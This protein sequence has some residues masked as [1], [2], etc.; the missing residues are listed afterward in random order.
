MSLI[1][2]L[3]LIAIVLQLVFLRTIQSTDSESNMVELIR[4]IA[5]IGNDTDIV[6]DRGILPGLPDWVTWNAY[7]IW[8]EPAKNGCV[9]TGEA[10][11][12]TKFGTSDSAMCSDRHLLK[13]R[14]TCKTLI[15]GNAEPNLGDLLAQTKEINGL[16]KKFDRAHDCVMPVLTD[17]CNHVMH[18]ETY[19]SSKSWA[20][21]NFYYGVF[22]NPGDIGAGKLQNC[23]KYHAR[24]LLEEDFTPTTTV[25]STTTATTS[26]ANEETTPTTASK[27]DTEATTTTN[28]PMSTTPTTATSTT[29]SKPISTTTETTNT[30]TTTPTISTTTKIMPT[31]EPIS[32]STSMATTKITI[33]T[34]STIT[35]TS[36][37]TTSTTTKTAPTTTKSVTSTPKPTTKPTTSR[38]MTTQKPT[39]TSNHITDA[40]S[41]KTKKPTNKPT[42]AEILDTKSTNKQKV[43][44]K[45]TVI[46]STS[47]KVQSSTANQKVVD[48]KNLEEKF[49]VID[50][51]ETTHPTKPASA[52]TR[53]LDL[54]LAT[55]TFVVTIW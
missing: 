43:V 26:A 42:T 38:T 54:F 37:A 9:S 30:M 35:T 25:E 28:T 39:T 51:L 49:A 4:L 41:V 44:T 6:Q 3:A 24:V 23:E 8:K 13:L 7:C 52:S 18:A 5:K 22:G 17:N 19:Y 48:V 21:F 33:A 53:A 14:Q 40:T 36:A 46:A 1:F 29:T 55:F 47:T 15:R 50:S 31:S 11:M 16:C 27:A 45:E 20:F 12:L 32:S 10:E 2:N 34:T